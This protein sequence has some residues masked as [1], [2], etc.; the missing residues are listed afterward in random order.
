MKPKKRIRVEIIA[1]GSE[2]LSPFFQD[3]NSLY[4][5]GRLNDLGMAVSFKSVVGDVWDDLVES[6][7]TAKSRAQII[8]VMGGLGPTEDDITREALASALGKDLIFKKDILKKIENRFKRRGFA[9]SPVNKKQ[10]YIIDG[11]EVMANNNGTAPGLWLEK[12]GQI[13]ALLPGPPHELKPMFEEEIWPRLQGFKSQALERRVL[14]IA[15]LTESK[16]E[17][18]ISDLYP[19]NP[20]INITPLAYPGQIELHLTS[21]GIRSSREVK[22]LIGR[23][24]LAI[25][26]R[27]GDNIFSSSDEELEAVVGAMLQKHNRTLAVAESCTGGFLGHRITNVSGSSAHFLCG[28]QVYSNDSKEKLLQIPPEIL[29]THGAVSEEV[30][31]AMAIN[32]TKVSGAD[33]GL[34]ITGIAGPTG[35]SDEK[36]VGLVY[37]GLAWDDGVKV[38]RNVFLGNRSAVKFQSSQKALDMLRRHLLQYE[39]A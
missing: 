25:R 1:V 33:F 17:T 15:G 7:I 11:A 30:A 29:I 10:A 38:L 2:L 24:E 27:L 34:S 36:P 39:K 28:L 37:T 19:E 8:F 12:E 18:L 31:Q 6:F 13:I 20:S 4:L 16:I 5:T 9:M 21:T 26:E 14:K 35:G 32:V 23:L 22:S 3:T